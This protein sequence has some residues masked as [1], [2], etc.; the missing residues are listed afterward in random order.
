MSY[1]RWYALPAL[2]SRNGIRLGAIAA[3][4]LGALVVPLP[5]AHAMVTGSA[6]PTAMCAQMIYSG[7]SPKAVVHTRHDIVVGPVRF[8]D[9]D[10]RLVAKSYGSSL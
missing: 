1:P 2:T 10:P 5:N 4:A 6:V 9:L 8:G 3:S 7:S